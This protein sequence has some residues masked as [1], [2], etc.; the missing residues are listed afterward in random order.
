MPLLPPC[1]GANCPR[2]GGAP[3]DKERGYP[4]FPCDPRT[5]FDAD[6][7]G[8]INDGCPQFASVSESGADCDN[9]TSDDGE[10][11]SVNDGCPQNGEV[12][13]GLRIPGTC[14]GGDEGGCTYRANP[15]TA[16][17]NTFTTMALSQRD[18]DGDGLENGFDT[19]WTFQTLNGTRATSTR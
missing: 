19:A 12:S 11:G 14:S 16:G 10:D 3:N 13:E 4:S 9:N 6:G 5:T 8:K 17:T 15:G 7:D 1:G 18:G 2:P